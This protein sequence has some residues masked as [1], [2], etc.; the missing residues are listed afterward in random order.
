[1]EDYNYTYGE[2]QVKIRA[3]AGE[4]LGALLGRDDGRANV[5]AQDLSDFDVQKVGDVQHLARGKNEA[6]HARRRSGLG[7][8]FKNCLSGHHDQRFF[9]SA[10]TAAAG[11]GRGRTDLA[12]REALAPPWY[13][14]HRSSR[15]RILSESFHRR[16]RSWNAPRGLEQRGW[17]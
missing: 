3:L 4:S 16:A 9:L 6:A 17:L 8:D 2:L 14:R 11:A 5:A 7:K 13:K 15:L 12:P 1:M 10:R